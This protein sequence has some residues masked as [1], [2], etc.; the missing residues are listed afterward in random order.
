MENKDIQFELEA[1]DEAFDYLHVGAEL[2][3][4]WREQQKFEQKIKKLVKLKRS[5]LNGEYK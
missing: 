2:A 1:I 5:L 3:R 4:D